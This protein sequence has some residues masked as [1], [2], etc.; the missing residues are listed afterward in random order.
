MDKKKAERLDKLLKE[1]KDRRLDGFLN[2]N[3]I[4]KLLDFNDLDELIALKTQLKKDGYLSPLGGQY[5]GTITEEGI[6]FIMEGGYLAQFK[7]IPDIMV[8]ISY[9]SKDNKDANK[10]V[11]ILKEL[12]INYFRDKKD[13]NWGDN[14]PGKIK[15]GLSKCTDL[16]VIISL[17]SLKSHW[18][19]FEI[20]GAFALNKKILPYLTHPSLANELPLYLKNFQYKTKP[21]DVKSY[22]ESLKKAVL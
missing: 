7:K 8:F 11:K 6:E 12:G 3:D 9:S 2:I 1:L 21:K 19:C 18:V 5:I 10:I 4:F 20:G 14:I 22:F 16:V 17:D 15:T 13:V